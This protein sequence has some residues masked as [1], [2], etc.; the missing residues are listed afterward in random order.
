M[1]KALTI[2]SNAK[3]TAAT[4]LQGLRKSPLKLLMA[5]I[6][7]LAG[8]FAVKEAVKL[9]KVS[10]EQQKL[11][12]VDDAI[13]EEERKGNRLSYPL[14]YYNTYADQIE[15]ATD[16]AGTDAS[17]IY[18]TMGAMNNNADVLQ[19]IK[20]YGK[21][22]NFA[23]FVPLGNFT[24]PQILISELSESEMAELNRILSTKGINIQ[25]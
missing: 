8:V 4:V 19:L 21:R 14:A 7:L 18:R 6:G 1:S 25:F 23:M 16:A 20:A 11:N 10:S 9:I 22:M 24:L 3:T 5:G 13:K 17:A 2:K 12:D 15:Q